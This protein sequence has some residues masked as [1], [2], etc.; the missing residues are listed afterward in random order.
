[1]D[2][3]VKCICGSASINKDCSLHG[4]GIEKVTKE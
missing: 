2:S 4:E 1:M 3:M